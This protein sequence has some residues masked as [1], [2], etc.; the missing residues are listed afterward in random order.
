M[1]SYSPLNIYNKHDIY[2]FQLKHIKIIYT[3]HRWKQNRYT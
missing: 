2:L 1:V 3:A